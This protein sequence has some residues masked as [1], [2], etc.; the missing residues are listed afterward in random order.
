MPDMTDEQR[1]KYGSKMPT[2]FSLS[3]RAKKLLDRISEYYGLNKS[4]T[5]EMLIR[6]QAREIGILSAPRPYDPSSDE[7][8]T[9]DT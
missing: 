8:G 2:S 7:Q 6:E 1:K 5:V 4:A 9:Q 3:D